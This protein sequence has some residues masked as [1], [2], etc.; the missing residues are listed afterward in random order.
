[1]DFNEE[2]TMLILE[3]SW[4]Y[5]LSQLEPEVAIDLKRPLKW[6]HIPIPNHFK[7]LITLIYSQKLA[8]MK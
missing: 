5:P 6:S 2:Q 3:N 1:M 4:K 7:I 8:L